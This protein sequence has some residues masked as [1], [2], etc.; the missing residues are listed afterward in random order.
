MFW[1]KEGGRKWISEVQIMERNDGS[2]GANNWCSNHL[3]CWVQHTMYVVGYEAIV[4][5]QGCVSVA[6]TNVMKWCNN[7]LGGGI[8]VN[9]WLGGWAAI[10]RITGSTN[11]WL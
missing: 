11:K 4:R 6:C 5:C 10:H 9:G 8:Q 2:I 7:L 1:K 3:G